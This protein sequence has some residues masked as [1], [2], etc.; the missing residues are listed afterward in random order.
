MVL[1]SKPGSTWTANLAFYGLSSLALAVS[2]GRRRLSTAEFA[3][4]FYLF[5][6]P[7]VISDLLSMSFAG[8]PAYHLLAMPTERLGYYPLS[9]PD[10]PWFVLILIWS[11]SMLLLCLAAAATGVSLRRRG[12]WRKSGPSR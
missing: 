3:L 7:C 11:A 10:G 8:K 12:I 1:G 4:A 9:G 5:A 6:A 2:G